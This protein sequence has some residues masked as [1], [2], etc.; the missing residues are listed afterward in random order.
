MVRLNTVQLLLKT[1]S[2]SILKSLKGERHLSLKTKIFLGV[3]L[4]GGIGFVMAFGLYRIHKR[5][6]EELIAIREQGEK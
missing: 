5:I 2:N 6:L 1:F 3:G 4:L